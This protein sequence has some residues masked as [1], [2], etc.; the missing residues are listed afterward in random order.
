M[1]GL[2]GEHAVAALGSPVKKSKLS[3]KFLQKKETK[4]TLDF[5]EP[6]ADEPE[7]VEPAEPEARWVCS[8]KV[9]NTAFI[10]ALPRCRRSCMS[11]M[12]FGQEVTSNIT[13]IFQTHFTYFTFL[14]LV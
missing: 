6:Q 1:P 5:S 4:R 7:A 9:Q 8:C 13:M 14:C 2:Q 10:I 12:F 3:L 11:R